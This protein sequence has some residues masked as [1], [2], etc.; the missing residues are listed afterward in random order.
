MLTD[1]NVLLVDDEP[2]V[3]DVVRLWLT[4]SGCRVRC[5]TDGK[6]AIAAIEAECPEIMIVDWKMPNMDGIELC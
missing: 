5:A 4:E 3:L 6:E 2:A 1:Q